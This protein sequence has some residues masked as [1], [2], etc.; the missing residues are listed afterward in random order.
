MGL[1]YLSSSPLGWD[2]LATVIHIQEQGAVEVSPG[3]AA[4]SAAK[5]SSNRVGEFLKPCD[6][7]VQVICVF[8]LVC[9]SSHSKANKGWLVTAGGKR[10]RP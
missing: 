3:K 6:N 5:V 9:G 4:R 7:W 1:W 8:L 2:W 10:M